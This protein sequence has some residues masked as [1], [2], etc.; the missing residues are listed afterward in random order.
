MLSQDVVD[1]HDVETT[2]AAPLNGSENVLL[3]DRF[4]PA[5]SHQSIS[6]LRS[7]LDQ[8]TTMENTKYWL[9]QCKLYDVFVQLDFQCIE[10]LGLPG[11]YM[12]EQFLDQLI[13]GLGDSD[14]RVR[15][16]AAERILQ[17]LDAC[18]RDQRTFILSQNAVEEF[19][20]DYILGTFA[21]PFDRRQYPCTN[22]SLQEGKSNSIVRIVMYKISNQLLKISDKNL[23]VTTSIDEWF[24]NVY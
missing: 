6:S 2:N 16:H 17:M 22:R 10:A 12:R 14:I 18:Q 7:I 1:R 19:V 24:L 21:Q 9:V 11:N 13:V 3:D 20:N 8:L 23:Q 5:A 15:N 4:E